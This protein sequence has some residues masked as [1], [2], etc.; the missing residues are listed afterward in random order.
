[1][2]WAMELLLDEDTEALL[3][4]IAEFLQIGKKYVHYAE[5]HL[6]Q[7]NLISSARDEIQMKVELQEMFHGGLPLCIASN[8]SRGYYQILQ[9]QLKS[10]MSR[11]GE[12]V[13]MTGTGQ[14]APYHRR[15]KTPARVAIEASSAMKQIQLGS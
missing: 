7:H 3:P 10:M 8:Y 5:G 11:T 2:L 15:C 13:M 1:M 14:A 12:I 9:Q 4:A 6:S